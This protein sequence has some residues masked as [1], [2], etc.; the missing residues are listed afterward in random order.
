ME[1]LGDLCQFVL[2]KNM[3]TSVA[4][5]EQHYANASNVAPAE[6]LTKDGNFQGDKKIKTLD[7]LMEY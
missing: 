5:L 4:M 6:K 1:N 7:W 3:G 2:A